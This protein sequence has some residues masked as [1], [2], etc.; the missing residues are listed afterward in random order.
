MSP[1]ASPAPS[2]VPVNK[3]NANG[4]DQQE[5]LGLNVIVNTEGSESDE[6]DDENG[7]EAFDQNVY[8]GYV[9]LEQQPPDEGNCADGE[10]NLLHQ[11]QLNI[12]CE[13]QAD[14]C[15][16]SNVRNYPVYLA[17]NWNDRN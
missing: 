6:S 4:G 13:S 9:A 15:V 12:F 14:D 17:V 2:D 11:Q 7:D 16:T 1:V 3:D 8:N 5:D 10:S